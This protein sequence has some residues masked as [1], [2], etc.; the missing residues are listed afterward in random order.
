MKKIR[1]VF[2]YEFTNI[3]R[4]RSFLLT[5]I[6][7]PL[8]GFL[9]IIIMSA[10]QK[11]NRASPLTDILTPST[12]LTISGLVDLSGIVTT[13][14]DDFAA[15]ITLIPDEEHA[16]AAMEE[17]E[18]SG[19]YLI[20]ADYL[21]VGRVDYYRADFNPLAGS[22][23]TYIIARLLEVNLLQSDPLLQERLGNLLNLETNYQSS[24]PQRDPFSGLT[25]F[26]PYG[27]TILFYILI[28]GTSSTMLSSV[29]NEKQHRVMEML[30]TSM[31]PTEMLTGKILA[32]GSI[33]LLQTITWLTS[34]YL[35]L[36]LSGR[37]FDIPMALEIPVSLILWGI[38]FFLLGYAMYASLMAGL[39]A[40]VPNLREASQATFVVIMPLIIPLFFINALIGQPNSGI[41]LVLSFFPLTSPVAMMTRLAATNLPFWQPLLAA[42]LQAATAYLIVK[43]VAGM[44]RAQ[45]LLTGQSFNIKMFIK[46]LAGKV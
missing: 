26:L 41:S 21:D 36:R 19:Y 27:I 5:L 39:G 22:E 43:S 10:L 30:L 6:L 11:D 46:A 44:F 16:L 32:L 2:K 40:M 17:Q 7:I 35:L 34:G 24:E 38:L 31:T 8:A 12:E 13:I 25:Y 42:L 3:L 29:A 18:I 33:G 14:P 45:T 15:L 1:T 23:N 9:V 37:S 28:L 4:S 20:P